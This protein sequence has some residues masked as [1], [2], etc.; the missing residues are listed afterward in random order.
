MAVSNF[1]GMNPLVVHSPIAGDLQQF[2]G[3]ESVE[4][5]DGQ[6]LFVQDSR[7]TQVRCR[8]F[9]RFLEQNLESQ[10]KSKPALGSLLRQVLQL[11]DS[12]ED[13]QRLGAISQAFFKQSG[14]FSRLFSKESWEAWTENRTALGRVVS[15]VRD[16]IESRIQVESF[17]K[18]L[19]A[20][21]VRKANQEA[22]A[23]LK[24]LDHRGAATERS[25]S[26]ASKHSCATGL[27]LGTFGSL[28][29][30]HPLPLLMG[31]SQCFARVSAQQKVGSEFQINTY[32]ASDQLSPSVASFPNGNFVVTWQSDG[33]DGS[34]DGI[35]AQLF[36][37]NGA[38]IGSEF[39]VNSYVTNSQAYPSVASLPNG[40]FVVTWQSYDQG[41]SADWGVYGQIF[42]GTGTKIGSEFPVYNVGQRNESPSVASLKDSNFVVAYQGTCCFAQGWEVHTGIFNETGKRIAENIANTYTIGAQEYP[43]V[44][45]LE[46]GYYFVVWQSP[47]DSSNLGIFA[48]LF[49][50]NHSKIGNEFRINSYAADDQWRPAVAS[51]KNGNFVVTWVSKWQDGD[52]N[53]IYS[54]L[55]NA[56]GE[57]IG[58]EFQV[59]TENSLEQFFPKVASLSNDHFIVVWQSGSQDGSSWGVYGQLFDETGVKIGNEFQVNTYTA[60]DQSKP[61]V[62]GL[63]N[64]NFVVTWHSNLQDGAGYGIYAQIFYENLTR[65]SSTSATSSFLTTITTSP[66]V[67][68]NPLSSSST[69]KSTTEKSTIRSTTSTT[70]P[71]TTGRISVTSDITS[72]V[73]STSPNRNNGLFWLAVL[74]GGAAFVVSLVHAGY[75]FFKAR[76]RKKGDD[77]VELGERGKP[78][79]DSMM[80][81]SEEA[82]A[83]LPKGES[84]GSQYANRPKR[85]S[86]GPEYANRPKSA[87][88]GEGYGNVVD[89]EDSE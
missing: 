69:R 22:G 52:L 56:Q 9:I 39:R 47:Q 46:N 4:H 87:P 61:S 32:I 67:T 75:S 48:Q 2:R 6:D 53:G 35:Y 29:T 17:T 66:T 85:E 41:I 18:R 58:G 81:S 24:G 1:H 43:S 62:A 65:S 21:V 49:N 8:T 88:L 63:P 45:S 27:A 7:V 16:C 83:N 70:H 15:Q 76:Q 40:S 86:L 31:L 23:F 64:E 82:Y 13:R 60:D 68:S 89:V 28:L 5:F 25:F 33:Q 54:Q 59:N 20:D 12:K 57:K 10:E 34:V 79:D 55:F 37:E 51:F 72:K 73:H 19:D 50:R 80:G 78:R 42:N 3:L 77:F 71:I 74:L 30:Q 38:K 26:I 84:L 11:S 36:D 44:A 14:Y